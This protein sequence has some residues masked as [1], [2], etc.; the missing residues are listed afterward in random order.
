MAASLSRLA[1]ALLPPA[2]ALVERLPK[3]GGPTDGASRVPHPGAVCPGP[4]PHG[5]SIH[6]KA[7]AGRGAERLRVGDAGGG[8]APVSPEALGLGRRR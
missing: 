8:G 2:L 3:P 1:G 4:R 5:I 6:A 7:G